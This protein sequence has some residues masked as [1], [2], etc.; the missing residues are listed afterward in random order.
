MPTARTATYAWTKLYTKVTS[1]IS[2]VYYKCRLC[3]ALTWNDLDHR[4]N[5]TLYCLSVTCRWIKQGKLPCVLAVFS[6]PGNRRSTLSIAIHKHVCKF[7]MYVSF[8]IRSLNKIF[9]IWPHADINTHTSC[10][11]VSLVWGSLRLAPKHGLIAW[12]RPEVIAWGTA[13]CNLLPF[14]IFNF[15]QKQHLEAMC[16]YRASVTSLWNKIMKTV[17]KK[18]SWDAEQVPHNYHCLIKYSQCIIRR[19]LFKVPGALI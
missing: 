17:L 3:T 15:H 7:E 5:R 19:H 2:N 14:T 1:W 10:S 4:R 18:S 6:T 12:V 13:K 8:G 16:C 11:A 9:G